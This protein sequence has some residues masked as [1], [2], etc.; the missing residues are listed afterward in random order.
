[1][2]LAENGVLGDAAYN[3]CDVM[4]EDS[5]LCIYSFDQFHLFYS[6]SRGFLLAKHKINH[7]LSVFAPPPFRSVFKN[8]THIIIIPYKEPDLA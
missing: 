5:S 4:T 2:S 3:L 8:R 7:V 1:M 6:L